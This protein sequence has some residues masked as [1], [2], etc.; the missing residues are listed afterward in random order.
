[1]SNAATQIENTT[2]AD[3]KGELLNVI[4]KVMNQNDDED[5]EA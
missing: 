5:D 2:V 4:N 3:T 1:L